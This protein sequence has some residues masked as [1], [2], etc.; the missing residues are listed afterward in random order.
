MPWTQADVDLLK[1]AILDRKGARSIAFSDQVVTFES[2]DDMMKLLSWM[3]REASGNSV[4]RYAA[5]SKG[6]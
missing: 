6:V 5:T 1:Q 3:Q 2:M 4:T